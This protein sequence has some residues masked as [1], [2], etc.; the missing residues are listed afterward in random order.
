MSKA[1]LAD[2]DVV[3]IRRMHAAAPVKSPARWIKAYANRNGII[4]FRLFELPGEPNKRV[5]EACEATPA[6]LMGHARHYIYALCRIATGQPV[7]VGSSWNP[8]DRNWQRFHRPKFR[9]DKFFAWQ[10]ERYFEL[11]IID[12]GSAR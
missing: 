4:P 10:G 3:R 5:A 8:W 6:S 2:E 9:S 1:Y 12:W 11:L 7:Y